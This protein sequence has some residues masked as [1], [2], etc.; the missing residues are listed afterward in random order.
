MDRAA[1]RRRNFIP[2]DAF[3]YENPSGL[4]MA[5]GGAKIYIDSGNYQPALDKARTAANY[6]ELDKANAEARRRGKFLGVGLSTYIEVC[7]VAPSK[8]IGAAAEGW[9]AAMWESA[10]L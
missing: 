8:W 6:Y 4:G 9:G 5:S 7:G 1:I 2:P 3:P 10:N